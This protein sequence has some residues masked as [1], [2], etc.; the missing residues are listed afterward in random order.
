M[1]DPSRRNQYSSN[2][3]SSRSCSTAVETRKMFWCDNYMNTPFNQV[4]RLISLFLNPKFRESS[5]IFKRHPSID[6]LINN[7]AVLKS[8]P[9][10]LMKEDDILSMINTNLI[11]PILLTKKALRLMVRKRKGHVV[12]IISMSHRLCKP[13]DSVYASTKAALEIFGKIVN[14]EVHSTGIN[15]NN[16]AISASP[17]GMLKQI[18]NL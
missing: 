4:F 15:V 10:L 8:T 2:T 14:V 16:L 11:G 12:N 5:R 1:H 13:G 9:L 7:A 6:V 3:A 18:T 17:T